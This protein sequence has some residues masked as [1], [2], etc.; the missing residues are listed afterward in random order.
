M[1]VLR[2]PNNRAKRSR[3][4]CP[5]RDRHETLDQENDEDDLHFRP[6]YWPR[7]RR[8][9]KNPTDLETL[10]AELWRQVPAESDG[11]KAKLPIRKVLSALLSRQPL[12]GTILEL[13]ALIEI[14]EEFN[15]SP[16]PT[17]ATL[18]DLEVPLLLLD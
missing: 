15:P 11:K 14:C 4:S 18:L 9:K 12:N 17:I 3:G 8:S 10:K 2:V 1:K 13:L 16:R 5:T 6:A 7:R